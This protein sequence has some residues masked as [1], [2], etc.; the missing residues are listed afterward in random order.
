MLLEAAMECMKSR[1]Q[2]EAVERSLGNIRDL[3]RH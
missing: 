3:M 2:A 1:I